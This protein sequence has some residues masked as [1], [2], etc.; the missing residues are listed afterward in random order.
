MKQT[1]AYLIL[2]LFFCSCSSPLKEVFE[3]FKINHQKIDSISG[4]FKISNL[5]VSIYGLD[6]TKKKLLMSNYGIKEY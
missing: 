3:N 6:L 4:Y 2:L 1:A 5:I